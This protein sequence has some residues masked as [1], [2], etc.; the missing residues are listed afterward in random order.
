MHASS[1]TITL[2]INHALEPFVPKKMINKEMDMTIKEDAT[3]DYVLN[4]IVGLSK[5]VIPLVLV[6]GRHAKA[7]D[8]L[9]PGD[10][11]T[12]WMPMAGG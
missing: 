12:L 3:I 8:R 9:N 11:V 5:Q 10:R 1:I 2:K 7:Q 6:N 4:E